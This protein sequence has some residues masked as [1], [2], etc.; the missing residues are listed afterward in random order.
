MACTGADNVFAI[1]VPGTFDDAQRVV[2]DCFGDA[3]FASEVNLS[4][5]NSINIARILAQCVY[6]I[7]ACCACR[8]RIVRRASSSCP[9]ETLAT[10]WQAGCASAWA[11]P[12][13]PSRRH[14]SERHPP[15]L[16]HHRRIPPGRGHPSHA[17]SMDIQAA[18]NFERFLYFMLGKDQNRVRDVMAQIK[19][20][21]DVKIDLPP[22][23]FRAS[24]M[25]DDTIPQA[26]AQMWKDHHYVIDPTHRLRLHRH[27]ARTASASCSAPPAPRSSPKSSSKPPAASPGIP[28]SKPSRPRRCTAG[29]WRPRRRR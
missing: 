18:S 25:D 2:K 23:T 13:A 6:Y 11:C 16:L 8:R 26:T 27:G 4:A 9:P 19:S 21:A 22:T 1:P 3:A 5:V 29:L 10:C 7:W 20:G 12:A 15:P 14:E 28:P 24:R 17:P